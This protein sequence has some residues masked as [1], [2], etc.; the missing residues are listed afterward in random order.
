MSELSR[1]RWQCRRG[2]RE[3]D[4]LLETYLNQHY[5]NASTEEQKLFVD[6]LG[7]EDSE[8]M[9]YL[10]ADKVPDSE[11][12]VRLINKIRDPVVPS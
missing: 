5:V 10:L 1:L 2:T 4:I 3:L 11:R 7:L 9:P 6:L 12:L 8:L